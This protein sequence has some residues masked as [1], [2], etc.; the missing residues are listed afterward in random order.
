MKSN[1]YNWEIYVVLKAV[2]ARITYICSTV[3]R[4]CVKNCVVQ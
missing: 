3:K 4:S 1:E 2:Y